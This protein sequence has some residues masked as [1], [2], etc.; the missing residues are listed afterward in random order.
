VVESHN[1]DARVLAIFQ[2]IGNRILGIKESRPDI[3][4][5]VILTELFGICVR[6]WVLERGSAATL[7]HLEEVLAGAKREHGITATAIMGTKFPQQ[8]AWY[9]D[10]VPAQRIHRYGPSVTSQTQSQ[11]CVNG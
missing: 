1:T 5:S 6:L 11:P 10:K 9:H 2:Q 4:Y 3:S 7:K 8:P